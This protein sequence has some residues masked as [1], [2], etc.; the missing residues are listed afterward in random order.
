MAIC[1]FVYEFINGWQYLY[2]ANNVFGKINHYPD[3]MHLF[4]VWKGFFQQLFEV[5]GV[6][7]NFILALTLFRIVFFNA[8]CEHINETMIYYHIVVWY[9]SNHVCSINI[10]VCILI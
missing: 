1:T 8:D 2:L 7:W 3:D 5:A 4:C 6:T 9:V 10:V